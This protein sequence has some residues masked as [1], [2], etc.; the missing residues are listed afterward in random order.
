ISYDHLGNAS[1][2]ELYEEYAYDSEG[3]LIWADYAE[4][5]NRYG[6]WY[7]SFTYEY[8]EDG[9][10]SSVKIGWSDD[11]NMLILPYYENGNVISEEVRC[12]DGDVFYVFYYYD[13]AGTLSAWGVERDGYLYSNTY[14]YDVYGNVT[15][16]LYLV[17]YYDSWYGEYTLD[18]AFAK[19]YTYDSFGT[20]VGMSYSAQEDYND[21][22]GYYWRTYNNNHDY[23][24][25]DQGR[26][27]YEYVTYG[28]YCYGSDGSTS[29]QSTVA[30]EINYVYG[31]YYIFN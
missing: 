2:N 7:D 21:Y 6:N 19:T 24:C 20:L 25:D 27:I 10:V 8:G 28:D 5:D 29:V 1:T 3:R 26:V 23:A 18:D 11:I 14:T 30:S 15:E 13:E 12:A 17:S 4:S 31:D 9:N 22:N 16:E